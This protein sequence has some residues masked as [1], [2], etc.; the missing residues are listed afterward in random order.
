MPGALAAPSRIDASPGAR[1]VTA[2][3]GNKTV[4][5]DDE[6]SFQGWMLDGQPGFILLFSSIPIEWQ[7]G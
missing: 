6:G 3:H 1:C 7:D 5:K 4:L 2:L